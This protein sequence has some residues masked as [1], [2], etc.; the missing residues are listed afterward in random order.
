MAAAT[1]PTE[2]H[3]GISFINSCHVTNDRSDNDN[4]SCM[5]GADGHLLFRKLRRRSVNLLPSF[6]I[7]IRQALRAEYQRERKFMAESCSPR[8]ERKC[9]RD[10]YVYIYKTKRRRKTCENDC[11]FRRHSK[12]ESGNPISSGFFVCIL[13]GSRGF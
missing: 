9:N 10:I 1:R 2:I 13:N 5:N 6:V 3:A 11:R 8:K 4:D 12:V 7:S